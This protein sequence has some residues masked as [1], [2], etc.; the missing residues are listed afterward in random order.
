MALKNDSYVKVII[1]DYHTNIVFS[2]EKSRN[3]CLKSGY[4]IDEEKCLCYG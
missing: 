2:R 3:F 1:I 4:D